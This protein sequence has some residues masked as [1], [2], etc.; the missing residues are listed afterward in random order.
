MIIDKYRQEDG[1]YLIDGVTSFDTEDVFLDIL[2][3]CGCGMPD[4]AIRYVR[5]CLQQVKDLGDL[6][7]KNGWSESYKKWENRNKE[8]FVNGGSEYFMWYYLDNKGFTEHG[9]S[10]PGWLTEKGLD[11]LSDLN[12]L[13]KSQNNN[14]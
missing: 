3:F 2:G 12:E 11:L 4:A 1:T 6:D 14:E 5:D 7:R 13:I 9:G 10:V 8:L